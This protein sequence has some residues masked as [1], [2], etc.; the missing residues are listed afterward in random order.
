MSLARRVLATALASAGA[1][2]RAA[3][4][5]GV[6]FAAAP[7]GVPVISVGAI[8]SGGSGKTPVAAELARRVAVRLGVAPVGLVCGGYGGSARKKASHVSP[9]S[10]DGAT[11]V[12]RHGDEALLLARWLPHAIVVAGADKAAAARL[13]VSLG[14]AAVLVDDGFQHRRLPRDLDVVMLDADLP[15]RWRREPLQAL[16]HADLSWLHARDGRLEPHAF[17]R[18]SAAARCATAGRRGIDVISVA[19]AR[20]VVDATGEVLFDAH[21]LRGR[22]VFIVAAV[23]APTAFIELVTDLGAQVV[24]HALRRDHTP[25]GVRDLAQASEHAGALLLTTEKDLARMAGTPLAS[26]MLALRCDVE[27][28]RGAAALE[29]ALERS[30]P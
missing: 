28:V 15:T 20:D 23:A 17:E 21:A 29:A 3:Y 27:I 1:L 22:R 13:A 25:L 8:A 7:I 5:R 4:Q 16:Q 30:M 24:G 12:A 2:R 9:A 19:R 6:L 11:L 10:A 26:R 18:A 14:A